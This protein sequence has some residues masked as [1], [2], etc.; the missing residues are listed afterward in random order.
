MG[1]GR[2]V[3]VGTVPGVDRIGVESMGLSDTPGVEEGVA[4]GVPPIG[5]AVPSESDAGDETPGVD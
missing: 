1:Y 2:R 5:P 3:A 4:P